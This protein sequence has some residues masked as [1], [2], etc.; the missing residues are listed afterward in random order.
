M[1]PTIELFMF[2]RQII[3]FLKI[4][5]FIMLCKIVF[6]FRTITIFDWNCSIR[7][8]AMFLSDG[9]E[10]GHVFRGNLAI[11]VKTSSSLLN[12]DLTPAAFCV[13]EIEMFI[14]FF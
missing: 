11:F 9:I 10:I 8:N 3:L 4:M 7:G 6:R 1:N 13:R 12:E 2:K 14:F 5:S